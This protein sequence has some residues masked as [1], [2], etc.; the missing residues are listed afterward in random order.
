[1]AVDPTS[2]TAYVVNLADDTVSVIER[3]LCQLLHAVRFG[4]RRHRQI[5]WPAGSSST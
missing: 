5:G 4:S 1:M 2:H 3:W